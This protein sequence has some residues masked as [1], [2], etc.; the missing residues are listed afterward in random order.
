MALDV[1]HTI[2]ELKALPLQDRLKVVEAVWD[3]ID[4]DGAT[5]SL[6]AGQKA[7]L[8]RRIAAHESNPNSVLTWDQVLE[9][10]RGRL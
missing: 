9:Q 8:D 4:E 10:M 7:E 1:N 3:S 5:V 6:S 2:N